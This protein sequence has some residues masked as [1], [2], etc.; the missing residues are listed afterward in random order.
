MDEI[1]VG[2]VV[3][4]VEERVLARPLH[5]VP[6]DMGQGRCGL[7]ADGSARKDTEGGRSVLVAPLEQELEAKADPEVGATLRQPGPDRLGQPATIDSL[8]G[9]GRLSDTGNE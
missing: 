5:L 1:E 9:R 2:P 6:A 7:E 8:H 4:P 3:D